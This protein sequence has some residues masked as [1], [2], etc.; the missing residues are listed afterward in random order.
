MEA[1]IA[2]VTAQERIFNVMKPTDAN[3]ATLRAE[4]AARIAALNDKRI[5][6]ALL[7]AF[8]T[9]VF[10]LVIGLLRRVRQRLNSA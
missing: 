6:I 1:D 5:E 2:Y 4:N 10:Q 8:F 9:G 3:Y 7:L